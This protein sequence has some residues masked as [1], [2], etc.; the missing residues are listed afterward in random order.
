MLKSK[1]AK[2]NKA[3]PDPINYKVT[4]LWNDFHTQ[5]QLENKRISYFDKTRQLYKEKGNQSKIAKVMYCD[6]NE[7]FNYRYVTTT[8]NLQRCTRSTIYY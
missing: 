4:V 7:N 8:C 6:T 5:N 3:H 2:P 1:F